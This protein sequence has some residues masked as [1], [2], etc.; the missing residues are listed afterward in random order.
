M[1]PIKPFRFDWYPKDS[2]IDFGGL[3]A[4]EIGVLIQI[5]NLLY[6]KNGELD[7]DPK[8][9][10]KHCNI[11][12][13]KCQRI[14]ERLILLDEIQLNDGNKI[15]KKRCT[16]ELEA[17]EERRIK[18]SKNGQK[19]STKR[20]EKE[21]NQEVKNGEASSISMART[22][23]KTENRNNPRTNQ[24]KVANYNIDHFLDDDARAQFKNDNPG[25][26]IHFYI[27]E[28]NKQINEDG[29]EP[30]SQS[31][32]KAFVAWSKKYNQNNPS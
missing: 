26:D 23:T 12:R 9:I 14:I 6:I 21:E 13:S 1:P 4:E 27:R 19:G 15:T 17:V 32:K 25:Q 16:Q 8:H 10:G 5:I 29:R 28:F 2:L 3:K 20:W 7:N 24:E 22:S 31:P 18:Y 11:T 30:P